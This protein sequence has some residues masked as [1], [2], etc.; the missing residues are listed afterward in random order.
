MEIDWLAWDM[1]IL[2]NFQLQF[3]ASFLF[4]HKTCVAKLIISSVPEIICKNRNYE[5]ALP[6]TSRIIGL[7]YTS[8]KSLIAIIKVQFLDGDLNNIIHSLHNSF[9][10]CSREK[11][12]RA[13]YDICFMFILFHYIPPISC[14]PHNCAV[15]K[16]HQ[17]ICFRPFYTFM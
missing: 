4:N 5:L 12:T 3:Q 8:V 9:T 1:H 11:W 2:M 13:K 17:K 16:I 6:T 10:I 15:M 14:I 7:S